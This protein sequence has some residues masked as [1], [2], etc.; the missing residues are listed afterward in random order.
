ML[1]KKC[2]LPNMTAGGE[3]WEAQKD[4]LKKYILKKFRAWAEGRE[5]LSGFR[6]LCAEGLRAFWHRAR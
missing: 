5:V 4:A 6:P 1:D 2:Y 3:N